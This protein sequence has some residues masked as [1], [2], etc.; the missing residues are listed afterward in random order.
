[1]KEKNIQVRPKTG[2]RMV[3]QEVHTDKT[4]VEKFLVIIR[5]T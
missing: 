1:M 5:K 2:K 3:L 4:H